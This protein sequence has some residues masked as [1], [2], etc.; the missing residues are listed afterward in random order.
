MDCVGAKVGLPLSEDVTVV[1]E[2]NFDA[3]EE[4]GELQIGGMEIKLTSRVP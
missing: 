1:V 4:L 3:L 2:F